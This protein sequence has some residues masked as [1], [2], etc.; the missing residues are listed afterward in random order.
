MS[1]ATPP[2]LAPFGENDVSIKS[3]SGLKLK[4]MS[5]TQGKKA[6]LGGSGLDLPDLKSLSA[7]VL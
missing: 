6:A 3:G 5:A 4:T 2:N 7:E 1:R